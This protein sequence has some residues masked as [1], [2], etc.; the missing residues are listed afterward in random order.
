MPLSSSRLRQ[1]IALR[2]SPFIAGTKR[3]SLLSRFLNRS[4]HTLNR[5]RP[6]LTSRSE[7]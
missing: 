6:A 7:P 3:S 4:S 1:S 5:S 2:T